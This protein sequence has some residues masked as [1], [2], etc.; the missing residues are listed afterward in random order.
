MNVSLLRDVCRGARYRA[1]SQ[2]GK[3][4]FLVSEY[5][6]EA[7]KENATMQEGGKQPRVVSRKTR[8]SS[9]EFSPRTRVGITARTASCARSLAI[10]PSAFLPPGKRADASPAGSRNGGKGT[11]RCRDRKSRLRMPRLPREFVTRRVVTERRLRAF[12][13]CICAVCQCRIERKGVAGWRWRRKRPP[14]LCLSWG[15]GRRRRRRRW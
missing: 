3:Y 13:E 10:F 12:Q 8:G 14:G 6:A 4:R 2:K 7:A 11:R 5:R 1:E 15:D 9:R